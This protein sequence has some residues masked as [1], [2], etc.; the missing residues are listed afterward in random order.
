MPQD[1]AHIATREQIEDEI[2]R[3]IGI[4]DAMDPDDDLEENGDREPWLG[5]AEDRHAV[6]LDLSD[7]R[8]GDCSDDEPSLGALNVQL[9][10]PLLRMGGPYGHG[11]FP[12][13][14]E[15]G[16]LSYHSAGFSQV[17]WAMGSDS[18]REDE[19]DGREPC[20]EDEGAQCD[21]EGDIS[22]SGVGDM[23]GLHE[24]YGRRAEAF[25]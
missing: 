22:D 5:W 24:V 14:R 21:D 1:F 8:E 6:I 17:A 20:S 9:A 4:L 23:D 18:D 7:D 15:T 16:E 11:L 10:E 12:M 19:H 3:L 13:H 2:E 25:I